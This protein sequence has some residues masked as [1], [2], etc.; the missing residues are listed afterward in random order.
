MSLSDSL[1][2]N[3]SA[4][5]AKTFTTLSRNGQE[6]TRIDTATTLTA[7]RTQ[8]IKHS[9]TGTRKTGIVNRHLVSSSHTVVDALGN[10]VTMVVNFTISAPQNVEVTEARVKDLIAF[11]SNLLSD[12]SR[13]TALLRGES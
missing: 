11:N 12:S 6:V 8:T 4:A 5:A 1:T 7:P 9:S 10:D 2:L 13:F 3:D